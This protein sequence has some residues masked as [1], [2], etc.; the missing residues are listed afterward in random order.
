MKVSQAI[1]KKMRRIAALSTEVKYLSKE[2]D[3]YFINKGFD[4][5]KIRDGNGYSL[6]ELEYGNDVTEEFCENIESGYYA[7]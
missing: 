7:K 5:E 6:E 2:V 3:D 4:I 1:K